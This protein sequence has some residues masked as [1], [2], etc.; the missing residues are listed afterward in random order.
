MK[1][2]YSFIL[3]VMCFNLHA[4]DLSKSPWHIQ[5]NNIDPNN[6]Y[7]I[8]VANGMVGM[9]SS[10]DP[11]KVEEV[12]LNGVYDYY[13]RGRVSNILKSFSHMN[14]HL[15]V[16][17]RQID[18][19]S[20]SNYAQTL[21]MQKAKL[22]TTFDVGNKVSV[23]HELMSLRNLPY[24]AMS[25]IEI[26]ARADVE[27]VP[28]NYIF[29]PNHLSDVRN[30]YSEIDRP[31]VLIPLM[32][33]VAFS[34][35]KKKLATST[36]F[37]F[38][39]K[40]GEEPKIIHEDWDYNM[41]LMK[42]KKQLKKGETYRFALVGSTISSVHNADP[43]NEAERLTIYAKLEGIKRLESAHINAWKKLWESDVRIEG[44]L[45]S[46]RAV[47][48]AIYHLYSFARKGTAYSLS[49]MGLSGLGYNGHVFWDTELW[50]YP[51]L[52]V[53]QPEIA[54][55]LLEYR[56]ERLG[57]AKENAFAHGYDGA[58]YPWE[59]AED[60]SEDTPVWA[61]TGPFQQHISATVGWAFWK[62]FEV[63]GDVEWLRTRGYPVLKEVA[64]FWSSR[65][66]RK[67]NGRYEINNVIGANEWEENID[68]NAFTNGM[69][70]TVLEYASK[71]AEKLD[72]DPD[73]DWRHV[74]ANIPIL[75]FPDGT[76]KENETYNGVTIKQ[77]DVNL[78][79]YPLKIVSE[80]D[81]I[82][83]DLNYYEPRLSPDGPAMGG[84]ILAV[85][86]ARLGE[87]EKSYQMFRKSYI[88]NELPP[89]KVIAET[90]GGTNPYFAT[91]AG[92]M[93]QSVIFGIGGL[94]ITENGIIQLN[95]K[96]P[97]KWKSLKMTGIG[98]KKQEF[99]R[100]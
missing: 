3:A 80:P 14:M 60:G 23:R 57:A 19:N 68:N 70:K 59:S 92:G 62:Y 63:T 7:G 45:E 27:V 36:S 85:L 54:K 28:I 32:S 96:L 38:P 51:P 76:T 97:K 37:I 65:V 13:Q 22:V 41:H 73:P 55:S 99:E 100:K 15:E 17:K 69:V 75:K 98:V 21:D 8:T 24:T 26:T 79:S 49:P 88:P 33:S 31:H 5:A 4:Q 72:L 78:L 1:V 16:D 71:A 25:I 42:F 61:L 86:Y 40:H 30:L 44:D 53:L 74:A 39:E 89:F 52:L 93:L 43:H 12:I 18:R 6:Y 67:G 66:E 56:F 82:K 50:M 83:R 2:F 94:D 87:E 11:L 10:P 9:V 48:S 34:P 91:G 95:T 46:Q 77:A 29:T 58:M 90:A 35:G 47:R 20:I 64:D 81:A 84:A